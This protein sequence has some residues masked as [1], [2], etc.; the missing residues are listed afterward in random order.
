[1]SPEELVPR[2]LAFSIEEPSWVRTLMQDF[3]VHEDV[4][5]WEE[6]G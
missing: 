2:I 3:L 5:G 4:A 1:M 6:I